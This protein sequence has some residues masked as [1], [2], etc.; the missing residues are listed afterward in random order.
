MSKML[1]F[2]I[3]HFQLIGRLGNYFTVL[4]KKLS[5]KKICPIEKC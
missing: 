4:N 1:P 3:R 5:N 2:Y